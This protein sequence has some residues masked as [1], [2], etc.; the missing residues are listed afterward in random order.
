M[1]GF[2]GGAVPEVQYLGDVRV[3]SPCFG[4]C[5]FSQQEVLTAFDDLVRWVTEGQR[6]A[7]GD[8]TIR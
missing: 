6:P 8:A 7:G 5:A 2:V 1:C 3:L 4:H